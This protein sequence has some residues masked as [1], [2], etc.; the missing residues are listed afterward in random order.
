MADS[1]S[2][3]QEQSSQSADG[4]RHQDNPEG[5]IA[6]VARLRDIADWLIRSFAACIAARLI[7][8]GSTSCRDFHSRLLVAADGAFLVLAASLG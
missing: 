7:A 5:K 2:G 4:Y 3:E 6:G 8:D 1:L